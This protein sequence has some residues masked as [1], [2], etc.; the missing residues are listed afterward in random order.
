MTAMIPSDIANAATRTSLVDL[1]AIR[2]V[3]TASKVLVGADRKSGLGPGDANIAAL[4]SLVDLKLIRCVTTASKVLVAAAGM[5]RTIVDHIV[6]TSG[7]VKK[8]SCLQILEAQSQ[9]PNVATSFQI[10]KI[11]S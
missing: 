6:A 7:H 4:T 10:V 3:T 9:T 5:M 8:T 11:R 2:C 1:K